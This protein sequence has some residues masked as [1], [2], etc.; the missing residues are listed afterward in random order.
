MYDDAYRI[1][2]RAIQNIRDNAAKGQAMREIFEDEDYVLLDVRSPDQE[3]GETL[4]QFNQENLEKYNIKAKYVQFPYDSVKS[5]PFNYF[6][7][8]VEALEDD[9]PA[10][11]DY[12]VD[13]KKP[14]NPI[15][16]QP[17]LILC[18][19]RFCGCRFMFSTWHGFNDVLTLQNAQWYLPGGK[20]DAFL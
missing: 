13:E 3:A 5:D 6:K 15:R 4:F 10:F 9:G 7:Q 17:I 2:S 8:V 1:D 14:V 16:N 11:S 20:Y 19:G 12:N 18:G